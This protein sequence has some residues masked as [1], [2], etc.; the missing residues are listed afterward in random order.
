MPTLSPIARAFAKELDQ[1]YKDASVI[2]WGAGETGQLQ[3]D[4]L[5]EGAKDALF[6]SNTGGWVWV[7]HVLFE[8]PDG[9]LLHMASTTDGYSL[10]LALAPTAEACAMALAERCGETADI[11][12]CSADFSFPEASTERE[13]VLH[14]MYGRFLQRHGLPDVCS[15]ELLVGHDLTPGQRQWAS[16]FVRV[17][18]ENVA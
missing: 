6:E 14:D 9:T 15:E 12:V 5:A 16:A 8:A 17:W 18:E 4:V 1:R 10:Y 11:D 13:I 3:H 2:D 7:S